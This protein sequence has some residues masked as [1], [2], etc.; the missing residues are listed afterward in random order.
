ME[1]LKQNIQILKILSCCDK[2]LKNKL[3][4]RGNKSLIN[5]LTECILNTLNGNI[6]ISTKVKSKL[7]KYKYQLRKILALRTNG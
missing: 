4:T 7:L 3:I 1:K 2:N 6:K 5:S